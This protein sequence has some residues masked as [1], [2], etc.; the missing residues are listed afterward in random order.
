[1]AIALGAFMLAGAM[2]LPAAMQ[3]FTLPCL[4]FAIF[5]MTVMRMLPIAISLAGGLPLR[6][7]EPGL[8]RLTAA[9]CQSGRNRRIKHALDSCEWQAAGTGATPLA[10]TAALHLFTLRQCGW[11]RVPVYGFLVRAEANGRHLARAR[12]RRDA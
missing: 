12:Y 1:M 6:L 11:L 5:A 8:S 9:S 2:L 7:L 4:L 3:H 10:E